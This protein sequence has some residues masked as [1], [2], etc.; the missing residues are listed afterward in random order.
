MIKKFIIDIILF[1]G[2]Q[3]SGILW[4][5]AVLTTGLAT[6]QAELSY[7]YHRWG[8][9][10]SLVVL[11]TARIEGHRA[12]KETDRKEIEDLKAKLEELKSM[13]KTNV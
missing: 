7:K 5:L 2:I 3:I 13:E 1:K 4:F 10:L 6:G 9:F 11:I 8:S 12:Q